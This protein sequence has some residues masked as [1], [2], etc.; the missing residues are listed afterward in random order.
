MPVYQLMQS[1]ATDV[2]SEFVG[3]EPQEQIVHYT[4]KVIDIFISVFIEDILIYIDCYDLLC[5]LLQPHTAGIDAVARTDVPLAILMN[6]I[7]T[8]HSAS[9]KEK[10]EEELWL[11]LKVKQCTCSVS[12]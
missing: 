4:S 7:T 2:L 1:V 10:Y 8:A 5:L 6:K 11:E 3:S 9:E 12:Q